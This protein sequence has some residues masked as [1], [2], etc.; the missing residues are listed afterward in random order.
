VLGVNSF[1]RRSPSRQQC[2]ATDTAP[3]V[4]HDLTHQHRSLIATLPLW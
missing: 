2:L 1:I 3:L 4:R